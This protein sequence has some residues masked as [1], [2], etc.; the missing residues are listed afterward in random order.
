[1]CTNVGS[2]IEVFLNSNAYGSYHWHYSK[3]WRVAHW[4]ITIAVASLTIIWTRLTAKRFIISE[5]TIRAGLIAHFFE[6]K[7]VIL[8]FL[9]LIC[10]YKL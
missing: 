5:E 6:E 7:G 3:L 1:M 9:T 2:V 8:A 10:R 4:T